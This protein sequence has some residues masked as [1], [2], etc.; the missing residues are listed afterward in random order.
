VSQTA[1]FATPADLAALLGAIEAEI[2]LSYAPAGLSASPVPRRWPGWRA[3]P[4]LGLCPS[5]DPNEPSLLVLRGSPE[6]RPREIRPRRGG[7]RY[8]LDQ[9]A[10][11][12]SVVLRPGG[13]G[14]GQVILAGCVG[15]ASPAAGSRALYREFLRALGKQFRPIRACHV[16][17]E[18]ER[19]LA[20][21]AR[22]TPS[23]HAPAA[24]DL[25]LE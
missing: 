6:L 13:L 25:R 7:V 21:G 16:G 24:Y 4:D 23:L 5:G 3:I 19:R 14:P 8:A 17:R 11:P 15:S 20:R 22:L 2:P 9:L 12:A 10:H 18:A 1:F